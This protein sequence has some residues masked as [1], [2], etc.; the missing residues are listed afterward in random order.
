MCLHVCVSACVR[1]RVC[2]CMRV[3]GCASASALPGVGG[4]HRPR[5]PPRSLGR[6]NL[7]R[8]GSPEVLGVVTFTPPFYK[9]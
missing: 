1:M 3:C 8:T 7:G 2:V 9:V 6:S 4:K 5:A